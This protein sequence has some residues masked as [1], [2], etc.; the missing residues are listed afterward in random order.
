MS[1]FLITE[2]KVIK[3]NLIKY[4]ASLQGQNLIKIKN[5]IF[6]KK[7]HF[8]SVFTEYLIWDD[9]QEFLFELYSKKNSY[10][11]LYSLI[12]ETQNILK[13]IL[14]ND[15]YRNLIK[16]NDKFKK[17]ILSKISSEI[18]QKNKR[19]NLL[20]DNN[21]YYSKILPS[22]LLDNT[23]TIEEK[24][25]SININNFFNKKKEK[26]DISQSQSTIDN[27]NA[28]NDISLSIDLNIN[29]KYDNNILEQNI[30][31]I[32]GKN[33]QNDTEL[34]K[35][36]K[37]LK[38]LN[39]AY[40][41]NN[42][43]K[44]K[45]IFLDYIHNKKQKTNKENKK[46]SQIKIK[47]KKTKSLNYMNYNNNPIINNNIPKNKEY[48]N[49]NSQKNI[50]NEESNIKNNNK[51]ISVN[52]KKNNP[53]FYSKSNNKIPTNKNKII[54]AKKNLINAFNDLN[55]RTTSTKTNSINSRIENKNV[56]TPIKLPSNNNI[57]KNFINN[58]KNSKKPQNLKNSE[59]K[60]KKE[61][62]I[63]FK[64]LN[65]NIASN[66]N[67]NNENNI[68][69]FSNNIIFVKRKITNGIKNF[70]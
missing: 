36:M 22:D 28:N 21:Y 67:N 61:K 2:A 59:I 70:H 47:R 17:T 8:T 16:I 50:F 15:Y 10:I 55:N 31:F 66:Y 32:L 4:N 60:I 54:P 56:I 1:K 12:Q 65:K 20:Y 45:N 34:I 37:Y 57:N 38:P 44:N 69:L 68:N 41:Y 19:S 14:I 11:N 53:K 5:L 33:D 30:E 52:I 49:K 42:S 48:F 18:S 63:D 25:N 3:I 6:H 64:N 35:V 40:I 39:T 7:S 62:S 29:K 9:T 23:T 58:D 26:K 24:K 27:V 46:T 43:K 51:Y 13:P